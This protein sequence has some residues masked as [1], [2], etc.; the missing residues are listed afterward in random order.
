MKLLLD[1]HA[2]VWWLT[3]D[4]KLS[5]RVRKAIA[6]ADCEVYVSAVTAFE[7]A[8]KVRLGKLDAAR[9]IA[10]RYEEMI[11]ASL[12]V[13][14]PVSQRHALAAGRMAGEH[15][16]PFDRLLAS[17]A[18]IEGLPLATIDPAFKHFGIKTIW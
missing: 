13:A 7:L 16:D 2:L 11:T 12:F 6:D 15:R 9:E 1:T 10:Q 14:L 3:D 5:T 4:R 8:T 18:H 17:Q